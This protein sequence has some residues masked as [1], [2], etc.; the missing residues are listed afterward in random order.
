M[1]E[2]PIPSPVLRAMQ[3]FGQNMSLARRRRNLTQ[4]DLAARLGVTPG[5]VRRLEAGHPGVAL[6]TI[7]RAMQVFGELEKLQNLLDTSTDSVGLALQDENLPKIIQPARRRK[8]AG[9][10]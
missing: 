8:N 2:S 9:A 6:Q 1:A 7:A 5:T 3:Q 4:G 10:F